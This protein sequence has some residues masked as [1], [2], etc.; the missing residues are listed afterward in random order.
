MGRTL[1]SKEEQAELEP[2]VL[3]ALKEDAGADGDVIDDGHAL[4]DDNK[5]LDDLE[6]SLS[7]ER[8]KAILPSWIFK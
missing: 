4:S 2:G 6:V 8:R 1:F 7:E 3:E 5:D